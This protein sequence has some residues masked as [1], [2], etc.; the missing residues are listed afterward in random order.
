MGRHLLR[1]RLL[2]R[3]R[4][5]LGASTLCAKREVLGQRKGFV[6]A[7]DGFLLRLKDFGETVSSILA[8]PVVNPEQLSTSIRNVAALFGAVERLCAETLCEFNE[9]A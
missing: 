5:V 7:L 4:G 6:K 8:H 1:S 9:Q 3:V 2:V